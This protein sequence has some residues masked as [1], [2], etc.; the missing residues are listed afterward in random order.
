[1]IELQLFSSAVLSGGETPASAAEL[2]LYDG[3]TQTEPRRSFKVTARVDHS[4]NILLETAVG[5]HS[6]NQGDWNE[7]DTLLTLIREAEDG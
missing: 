6:K 7:P 2:H 3:P 5:G 1:M 4:I